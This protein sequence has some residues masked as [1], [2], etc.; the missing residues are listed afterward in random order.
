MSDEWV[1][2]KHYLDI[3]NSKWMYVVKRKNGKS[4]MDDCIRKE[5][6]YASRIGTTALRVFDNGIEWALETGTLTRIKGTK[7]PIVVFETRVKG[8]ILRVATYLHENSIPIYLFI[9][10]THGGSNNNLSEHDKQ[11]AVEMAKRAAACAE[12][13]MFGEE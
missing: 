1:I 3:E 2:D 9:F 10:R 7:G 13:Y 6:Q 5:P 12:S 4:F 11:H 8:D